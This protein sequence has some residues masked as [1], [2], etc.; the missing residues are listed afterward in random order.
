MTEI[1]QLPFL[2]SDLLLTMGVYDYLD[3]F[4]WKVF[5][6][7]VIVILGKMLG[8]VRGN[9]VGELEENCGGEP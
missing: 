3:K 2:D 9:F 6:P 5:E 4:V 1:L 7:I 8:E